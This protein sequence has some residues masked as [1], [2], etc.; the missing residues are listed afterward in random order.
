MG[1]VQNG[2]GVMKKKPL[3]GVIKI[4]LGVAPGTKTEDPQFVALEGFFY[5]ENLQ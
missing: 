3:G 1:E 2:R 4:F 5:Q